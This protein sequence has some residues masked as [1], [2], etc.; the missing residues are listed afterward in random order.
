MTFLQKVQNAKDLIKEYVDAY[1][2]H[3]VAL[4]FGKDSMVL[5]HLMAQI[6]P[7]VLVFAVL[8]NTEFPETLALRDRVVKDW[9]LHYQE[10]VFENDVTKGIGD[11]CRAI[12]VEKFKEAVRDLD[13]WF[14][15]IRKD[16]GF[17]RVDFQQVENRDGLLKINPILDFTEKDIWRYTAVYGLPVNPLYGRGYR[18]LSCS[19]CSAMEQ[20]ENESERAGRWK[21]TICEGGECGIHTQSLRNTVKV[22]E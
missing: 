11:C 15:G 5:V 17:T 18:S 3:G 7:K 1:P 9:N 14:S 22:A 13:C 16:E 4:S 8:S 19:R 6:E 12:K 2:R 21:G 10:Y 20:D